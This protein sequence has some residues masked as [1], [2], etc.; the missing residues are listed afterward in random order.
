MRFHFLSSPAL[1][2]GVNTIA[3]NPAGLSSRCLNDAD[4]WEW[5]RLKSFKFRIFALTTAAYVGFVEGKPDTMPGSGT[6]VMELLDAVAHNGP[7]ET[8]WSRWVNIPKG[9]LA[10]PLPWYKTIQGTATDE[11]E[12]QGFLALA[13]TGTNSV[14]VE[15]FFDIE[16]K[17]PIATANTPAMVALRKQLHE[18]R[19]KTAHAV[20]RASVLQALSP[21]IVGAPVTPPL[22]EALAS[23]SAAGF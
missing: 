8:C 14:L 6:Q 5:Y 22:R 11:E 20:K 1:A 17:G 19:V 12:L 16:F 15:Y 18:E 10:G 23:V 21:T 13:G 3:L 7:Q 2:A 4:A 9:A